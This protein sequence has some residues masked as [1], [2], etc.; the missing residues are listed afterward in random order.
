MFLARSSVVLP[1]YARSLIVKFGM[2]PSLMWR[3][4]LAN[5]TAGFPR[6]CKF[7]IDWL[8][9]RVLPTRKLPSV[10]LY[11]KD[12]TYPL[13]FNAE[14][15][16]NPVVAGADR[17]LK[18]IPSA[19]R[20]WSCNGRCATASSLGFAKL[21]G[22]W[23]AAVGKSG[24]SVFLGSISI[25]PGAWQ[26]RSC[27][28]EDITSALFEWTLTLKPGRRPERAIV[29]HPRIIRDRCCNFPDLGI[30]QP[31]LGSC[32]ARLSAGRASDPAKCLVITLDRM[33]WSNLYAH[34][35]LLV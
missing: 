13:E 15:M 4:H 24:T 11:R 22:C 20:G 26:K 23:K 19:C 34:N 5:T 33:M 21:T 9:R 30:C 27:L 1:E 31:N 14:H 7:G 6:L 32:R 35:F 16:P 17:A 2:S 25:C 10:F 8:K 29:G 3:A 28:K 18:P 12:G